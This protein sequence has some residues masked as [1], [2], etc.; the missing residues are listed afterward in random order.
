VVGFVEVSLVIASCKYT[1]NANEFQ[2]QRADFP[3]WVRGY[4]NLK[5]NNASR[6][7]TAALVRTMTVCY[8]ERVPM[9][10]IAL[11]PGSKL[12]DSFANRRDCYKVVETDHVFGYVV[13]GGGRG[14][15]AMVCPLYRADLH[16]KVGKT[17]HVVS[18]YEQGARLNG[19]T[20][21]HDDEGCTFALIAAQSIR[22]LEGRARVAVQALAKKRKKKV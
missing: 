3:M 22:A 7:R 12:S 2:Q 16:V 4:P 9:I 21:D 20:F 5:S 1:P 18:S 17:W 8:R 10:K 15:A 19:F 14:G 6:V 13:S 11:R